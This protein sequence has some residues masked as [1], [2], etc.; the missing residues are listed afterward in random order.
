MKKIVKCNNTYG[1]EAIV[2]KFEY[3]LLPSFEFTNTYGAD[4]LFCLQ[5]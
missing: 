2:A 1:R 3:S 5:N 4:N